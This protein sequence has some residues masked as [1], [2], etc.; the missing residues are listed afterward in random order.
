MANQEMSMS[1]GDIQSR[2]GDY[3]S[4]DFNLATYQSII[5]QVFSDHIEFLGNA[6]KTQLEIIFDVQNH[7]YLLTEIGWQ[8]YRRIYH[9]LLHIDIIDGKVWI[10][11]DA[12]EEGIA[13]ELVALGIPK[14][15]IVL[16]YKPS[17]RR[18]FTEFA[19][20]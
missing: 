4:M 6:E 12:T 16:G 20:C 9:T 10:Q 14:H 5:R 13:D 19:V 7:H 2:S 8:D 15:H 11:Q 18:R 1:L 3:Q 17:D